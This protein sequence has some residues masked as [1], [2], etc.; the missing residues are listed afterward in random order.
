MKLRDTAASGTGSTLRSRLGV[1]KLRVVAIGPLQNIECNVDTLDTLAKRVEKAI[2]L[3]HVTE[4]ITD[5]DYPEVSDA[6]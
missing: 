2:E 1:P 6:Y 5:A 4:Y 3:H